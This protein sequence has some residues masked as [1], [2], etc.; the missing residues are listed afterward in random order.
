MNL[1][2]EQINT[3]LNLVHEWGEFDQH[4]MKRFFLTRAGSVACIFLET[5]AAAWSV[6]RSAAVLFHS[7]KKFCVI[8]CSRLFPKLEML[9]DSRQQIPL[10]E[11]LLMLCRRIAGLVSTLFIGIFSPEVNFRNH[12]KLHLAID[13]LSEKKE[14]ELRIRLETELK[15]AQIKRERLERFTKMQAEREAAE[16]AEEKERRID[17]R[18]AELLQL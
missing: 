9:M 13:N 6:G 17:S 1:L 8:T 4:P 16:E 14:R 11:E 5:A 2:H 12:K 7:G 18:L 3:T 15:A 10:K